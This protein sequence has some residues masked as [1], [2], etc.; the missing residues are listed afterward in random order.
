M[1]VVLVFTKL[2]VISPNDSSDIARRN[3][4]SAWAAASTKCDE[5]RRFPLGNVRAEIV[6][7]NY[8]F[9]YITLKDH[10]TPS[11]VLSTADLSQVYRQAG[12]NNRRG[13]H[14]SL[15]Q[16][17]C[18]VRKRKD[19]ITSIPCDIGVVGRTKSKSRH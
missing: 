14:F 9:V 16:Y 7:S 15:T 6:S 5:F 1:P 17:P 2:D 10:L 19:T 4:E 11:S 12:C 18:I 8:S 3:Y 13:P